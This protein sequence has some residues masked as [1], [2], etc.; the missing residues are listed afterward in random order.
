MMKVWKIIV[1]VGLLI[2]GALIMTEVP[3]TA[4]GEVLGKESQAYTSGETM[5]E[6]NYQDSILSNPRMSGAARAQEV[7]SGD[8]TA[9]I[10][11]NGTNN[12]SSVRQSGDN[13]LVVHTQ[14]G[15]ENE[16]LVEQSGQNNRSIETLCGSRNR[17]IIIQ[18]DT[19]TIIEQ[20][21]PRDR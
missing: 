13:N 6:K 9:I 14:N 12:V 20:V 10:N 16:I 17:K 4:L 18:N 8:N 3:N 19:E 21:D 5:T 7:R 11:Q 2:E 1:V 15:I